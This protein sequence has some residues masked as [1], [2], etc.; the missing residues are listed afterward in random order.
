M[1]SHHQPIDTVQIRTDRNFSDSTYLIN[2]KSLKG[3]CM[4]YAGAMGI[5][6]H[7][8]LLPQATITPRIH[9]CR[10]L[11]RCTSLRCTTDRWRKTIIARMVW[12]WASAV[13]NKWAQNGN[14]PKSSGPRRRVKDEWNI[15]EYLGLGNWDKDWNLINL[16]QQ[17]ISSR[18]ICPTYSGPWVK[19]Q[20]WKQQSCLRCCTFRVRSK[21]MFW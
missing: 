18:W 21:S 9:G 5:S 20:F 15:W 19:W 14:L 12:N 17:S 10:R 8:G 1:F 11:G 13:G 4:V 7:N 3:L 6:L 2:L 16:N